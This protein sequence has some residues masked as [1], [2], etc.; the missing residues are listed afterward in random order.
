VFYS[1]PCAYADVPELELINFMSDLK[2]QV[3]GYDEMLGKH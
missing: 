2:W 3:D 1:S